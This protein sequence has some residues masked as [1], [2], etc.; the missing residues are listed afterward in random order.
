MTEFSQ[1]PFRNKRFSGIFRTYRNITSQ[2]T[3]VMVK[4]SW[5]HLLSSS[6]S[7][8]QDKYIRLSHSLSKLLQEFVITSSKSV[9]KMFLRCHQ[10]VFKTYYQV[11]L[12][13]LTCLEG[14]FNAFL[15]RIAKA[16]IYRNIWLG[17]IS[18]KSLV[19]IQIFRE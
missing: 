14:L 3:F 10:D 7:V 18:E 4:T 16:I 17:H 8:D 1:S 5:R 19:R 11:K 12:F 9:L 15:R 2:Q 6:W 13:F